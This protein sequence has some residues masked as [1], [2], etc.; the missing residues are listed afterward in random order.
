MCLVGSY[1]QEELFDITLY[2]IIP[3]LC[4]TISAWSVIHPINGLRWHFH[5]L[6]NLGIISCEPFLNQYT[7]IKLIISFLVCY[8][9]FLKCKFWNN[10]FNSMWTIRLL[11]SYVFCR[12]LQDLH[13]VCSWIIFPKLPFILFDLAHW[14]ISFLDF[15]IGRRHIDINITSCRFYKIIGDASPLSTHP[16]RE[17]NT[18]ILRS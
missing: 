7:E 11:F 14:Q 1:D 15:L 12:G 8:M 18:Y 10:I 13:R 5:V 3:L 6:S 17:I 4:S 2:G 9:N 16:R